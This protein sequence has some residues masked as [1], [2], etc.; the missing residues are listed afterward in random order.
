MISV[1]STN[2]VNTA[3][4]GTYSVIYTATDAAGNSATASRRVSVLS[5]T[6]TGLSLKI[7]NSAPEFSS[8]GHT[9]ANVSNTSAG[10]VNNNYAVIYTIN[11]SSA[12][13]FYLYTLSALPEQPELYDIK[14]NTVLGNN[15][16]GHC[17]GLAYQVLDANQQV[18]D[19]FFVNHQVDSL[20]GSVAVGTT[21]LKKGDSIRIDTASSVC[22]LGITS[23]IVDELELV[24]H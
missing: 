11:A 9:Q 18:T 19:T 2:D 7:D 23:A 24:A 20:Y 15:Y 3:L 4:E 6:S 16:I 10:A 14:M 22:T 21:V 13:S 1:S 12:N 17:E 8:F 5:P